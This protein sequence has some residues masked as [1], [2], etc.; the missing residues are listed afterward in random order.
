MTKKGGWCW[1]RVEGSR[2]NPEALVLHHSQ[3]FLSSPPPALCSSP[4]I[5]RLVFTGDGRGSWE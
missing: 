1:P 4:T 2:V 5:L 3:F